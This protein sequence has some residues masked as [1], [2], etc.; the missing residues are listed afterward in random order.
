MAKAKIQATDDPTQDL[1]NKQFGE[2]SVMTLSGADGL[3][4]TDGISTGSLKVDEIL[5]GH[6]FAFG[7]FIEIL[8]QESC[9]KSSLCWS[10]V[11]CAQRRGLCCVIVDAEQA[12]DPAWAENFGVD[13]TNVKISQ[14]DCGEEGLTV[15]EKY[16]QSGRQCFIVVDSIAALIPKKL[17]EGEFGDASVGLQARMMSQACQKLTALTKRT[18]SIV[19]WVNQLRQTI[20]PYQPPEVPCGGKS[21]KFYASQRLDLRRK[22][23]LKNGET[24]IGIEVKAKVIKNKVAVPFKETLFRI[25]AKGGIRQAA[26]VFELAVE[27][28]L[29]EKSGAWIKLD[30]KTIAQGEEGAISYLE[31]NPDVLQSLIAKIKDKGAIATGDHGTDETDGDG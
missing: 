19:V 7:R 8:G 30:G 17:L 18:N 14:P 31:E 26:E 15:V 29:L 5:G 4:I 6:G 13:L 28:K 9:G 25:Y 21:M 11:A 2:G 20:G 16:L 23:V 3:R 1:L 24:P 12:I 27:K 22:E 10:A